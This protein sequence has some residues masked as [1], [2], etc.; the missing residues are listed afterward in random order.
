VP[1]LDRRVVDFAYAVPGS[2]RAA[3]GGPPKPLLAGAL[4]GELRS[5]LLALPKHGFSLPIG[6][7]MRGP[8][9]EMTEASVAAVKRHGLF[10]ADPVWRGFLEYPQGPDW[11]R[12]WLL[13][14]LGRWL[15]RAR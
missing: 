9:R 1:L 6:S 3:R 2:V 4:A 7:W 8:L 15:E 5:E 10:D 12:V 14:V 13:S 11:S